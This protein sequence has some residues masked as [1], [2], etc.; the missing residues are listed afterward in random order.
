MLKKKKLSLFYYLQLKVNIC[1]KK[2]KNKNRA[3]NN[4]FLELIK[5]L[6]D[7]ALFMYLWSNKN[8]KNENK[9]NI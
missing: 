5:C 6:P 4:K 9:K 3:D 8:E 7:L 1:D 2:I